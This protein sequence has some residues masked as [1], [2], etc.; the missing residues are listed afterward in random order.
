MEIVFLSIFVSVLFIIFGVGVY[1]ELSKPEEVVAGIENSPRA[2]FIKFI[3]SIF[4]QSEYR[5]STVQE[6]ELILS[7]IRT[8]IADMESDGVYFPQ[9]VKDELKKRKEELRCEYSGLPSVK[10]Y[11]E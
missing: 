4:D 9:E 7:N 10:S 8:T 5:N 1:K 11:I 6:K 2:Q 3:G